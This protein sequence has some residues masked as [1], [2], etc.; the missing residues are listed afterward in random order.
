MGD[1]THSEVVKFK[2]RRVRKRVRGTSARPRLCVYKSRKHI[3]AQIV[4]DESG[5]VLLGVSTNS[6]DL[7]GQVKGKKN[8][9][10]AK[11]V[12]ALL[13]ERAKSKNISAVCFDRSGYI[14]HGKI[15]ALADGARE[16]G[17]QF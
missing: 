8:I 16:G 2:A 15:A 17:L 10:A 11:A 5:R 13:A 3:L 6:K 7:A 4:D 12:G 9:Q 1:K 14:Y